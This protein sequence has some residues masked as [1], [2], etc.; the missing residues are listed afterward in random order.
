MFFHVLDMEEM[1]LTQELICMEK[2]Q[3]ADI[4]I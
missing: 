1:E 2:E 4:P 3:E